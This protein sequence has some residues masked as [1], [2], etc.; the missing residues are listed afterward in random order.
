MQKLVFKGLFK[1]L[2]F[3]LSKLREL[4]ENEN[5]DSPNPYPRGA[6]RQRER[7]WYM[8]EQCAKN[9]PGDLL[10]IG[11]YHGDTTIGLCQIAKRYGKR[12]IVVD[13]YELGTQNID[14]GNEYQ[15]FLN[16]TSEFRELIDH[17]RLSS[18][19]PQ[20][21]QAVKN[22]E[23]C[24]SFVDGLH[25]YEAAS[26]DLKTVSHTSGVIALDDVT[27]CSEVDR[28]GREFE[29]QTWKPFRI[30]QNREMFFER[31]CAPFEPGSFQ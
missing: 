3:S 1:S 20:A 5:Y 31:P 25:N 26:S 17:Y 4:S 6:S 10:E 7:I 15:T 27:W 14:T 29:S 12:V 13:P 18:L 11:A 8:A 24:F 19:D 16:N 30:N 2:M 28:A 23:L 9:Y 22:R 21:I